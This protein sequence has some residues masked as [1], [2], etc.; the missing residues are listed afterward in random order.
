MPRVHVIKKARKPQGPCGKCETPI[1]PGDGYRYWE[2]RYGGK[3]KRCMNHAC[4]PTRADL[5]QSGYLKQL[6]SII[7]QA[8]EMEY[9]SVEQFEEYR[10]EL[11]QELEQ[12]RD[13]VQESLDNM[14]EHLQDSSSSGELLNERLDALEGAISELECID[15]D[16]EDV[17][18]SEEHLQN[19][20]EE[21][22]NAVEYADC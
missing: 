6:Y 7:D 2:F 10:D 17:E 22:N 12:L 13:E 20:K 15:T 11:V 3:R 4:K 5:T 18:D 19:L 16:D 14:P 1:E 8:A 21:L 9:T